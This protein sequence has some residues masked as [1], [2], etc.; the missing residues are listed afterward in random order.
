[1]LTNFA[2]YCTLFLALGGSTWAS[3]LPAT[4]KS[5][6]PEALLSSFG[7][8][9]PGPVS[10]GDP[11]YT[12]Q[13]FQKL[14]P[15]NDTFSAQSSFY[16]PLY[17]IPWSQTCWLEPACVVTP[18]TASDLSKAL[19]VLEVLK[20]KFA[21]R[22]GGHSPSP[23]FSSVG[24]NGVLLALQNLNKLGISSDKKTITIGTGNRWGAV[25]KY[26]AE[27]GVN[28][29]GGREPMVGVGGFL[30]GGGLSLFYNTY[31][32]GMDQIVRYQ[33]VLTNGNIVNATPTQNAD[34]YKALKGGL[35]NM[36]IVTEF[37]VM[38][39]TFTNI[40]Y[41]I[42]LYA[43]SSTA[44]LI[45]AYANYLS[46]P[47]TDVNSNVELEIAANFTLAFYG[48]NA[49]TNRPKV[50]D[51]FYKIPTTS[52][53]FPPTNGTV[54]DIVFGVDG[55]AKPVGS[56]YGST[57]SHRVSNGKF[58][59]ESY[60]TYLGLKAKLPQ[61]MNFYYIPQGI[62]PNLVK[63]GK[64]R[65]GGNLLGLSATPQAWVDTYIDYADLKNSALAKSTVDSFVAT[66]TAKAAA[67]NISLPYLYVNNAAPAQKPL[68]AYGA[69]SL[70]YIKSAA[71]KYDPQGVMQNLQNNG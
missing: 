53:F 5:S 26:A 60:Q 40:Y 54:N 12:C 35:T 52:T 6:S 4:Q 41:E 65:N 27:N 68:A 64:A 9:L 17:E 56:T 66:M 47:N 22:S 23:G 62:T 29:V 21:T 51:P 11:K 3:A 16:T 69:Q 49:H 61:G 48:Y 55:N 50:F 1:M 18:D 70:A 67:E 39:N 46:D 24:S 7:V 45:D 31:G 43:P 34:L 10:V 36:G 42:Y 38:T 44:A 13:V 57:F 32:L 59:Q 37:E 20:T 2:H 8:Q 71:K 58:M 63:E 28:I 33:V 15:K 30:L 25:Y 19:Q 14:F